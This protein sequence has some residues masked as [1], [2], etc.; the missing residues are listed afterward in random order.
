MRNTVAEGVYPSL[1]RR[2]SVPSFKDDGIAHSLDSFGNS[3]A[4]RCGR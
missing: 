4:A 1:S 3:A 2:R